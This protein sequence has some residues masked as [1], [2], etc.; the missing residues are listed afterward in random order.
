MIIMRSRTTH[1]ILGPRRTNP[2]DEIYI[3]EKIFG[4]IAANEVM[5]PHKQLFLVELHNSYRAMNSDLKT[6]A[7]VC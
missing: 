5:N 2:Y 1:D 6:T 7:Y 3:S 4:F